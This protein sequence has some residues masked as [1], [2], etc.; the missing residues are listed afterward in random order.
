MEMWKR[1]IRDSPFET[2]G[3]KLCSKMA[4]HKDDARR[5]TSKTSMRTYKVSG[6]TASS[7]NSTAPSGAV[8]ETGI[9]RHW[10]KI[11]RPLICTIIFKLLKMNKHQCVKTFALRIKR[12]DLSCSVLH[13]SSKRWAKKSKTIDNKKIIKKYNKKIY[14]INLCWI[15]LWS[16]TSKLYVILYKN[17][18]QIFQN[19]CR[20]IRSYLLFAI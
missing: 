13:T 5:K 7:S 6:R 2:A 9:E 11:H 8:S 1:K 15:Y 19:L 10:D 18:F 20:D 12:F 4:V 3:W 14:S 16:P 17:T